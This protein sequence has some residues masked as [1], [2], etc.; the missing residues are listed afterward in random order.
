M[1]SSQSSVRSAPTTGSVRIRDADGE[2]DAWYLQRQWAH[3]FGAGY[4]SQRSLQHDLFGIAGWSLPDDI[5]QE[6]IDSYGVIAEHHRKGRSVRIGGGVVL[7]VPH[8]QA[9]EDLP[10]DA[11]FDREALAS[12]PTVWFLLGVVDL[13][14]RGRGIGRRLFERRLRW[15]RQTDAAVAIACG[16]ERD[17]HRTSRPLFEA[18]GWVPVERIPC[19]YE[20][21]TSCP[22]CDLWRSD[23]E[24]GCSCEGTIWA[25]DL[26]P[27]SE[28]SSEG[29]RK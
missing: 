13:A 15:A 24:K 7:L 8:E 18:T 17:G 14:W 9:V 22:D 25:L 5:D 20:N 16:W 3:W 26:S 23:G 27:S 19:L 10:E 4:E 29:D 6:P 28:T 1:S 11:S 21:R 12:D 2:A